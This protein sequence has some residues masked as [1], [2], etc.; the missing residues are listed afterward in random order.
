[1]KS[2]ENKQSWKRRFTNQLDAARHTI[3][4]EIPLV[5]KNQ[6]AL[7]LEFK[8][9]LLVNTLETMSKGASK[10]HTVLSDHI[11][12]SKEY[13]AFVNLKLGMFDVH[14]SEVVFNSRLS[15]FK[16]LGEE[17]KYNWYYTQLMEY[18]GSRIIIKNLTQFIY[19]HYVNN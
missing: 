10:R 1:M 19:K 16:R 5:G 14:F 8:A 6:E 13:G 9:A 11:F 15:M 17:G 12:L 4:S 18:A 7:I 2:T 3:Q